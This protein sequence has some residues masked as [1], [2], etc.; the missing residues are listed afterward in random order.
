MVGQL[1][2]WFLS[3]DLILALSPQLLDTWP[4]SYLVYPQ[5]PAKTQIWEEQL[6]CPEMI[7]LFT[8]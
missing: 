4:L 2:L 7:F 1:W 3:S 8:F 6:V 5:I